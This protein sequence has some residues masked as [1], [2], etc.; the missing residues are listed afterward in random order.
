MAGKVIDIKVED[1]DV[2]K[3]GQVLAVLDDGVGDTETKRLTA[4]LAEAKANYVYLEKFYKR[5]TALYKA[6]Q[7]SQNNYDQITRDLDISKAKVDQTQAALD[8][9]MQT[10]NNLFIKSPAD[11]IV[12]AKRVD[13]GQMVTA[14]LQATVLFEIAKDLQ[15]WKPGLMWMKRILEW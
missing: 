7:I 13:L 8:L 1:N 6:G 2:V 15:K 5:Q 4:N 3:K 9:A 11:G 10:Y 14:Q 12:I